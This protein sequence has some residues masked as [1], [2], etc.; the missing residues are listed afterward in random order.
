MNASCTIYML[1]VISLFN[2]S[3]ALAT[4]IFTD[5]EASEKLIKKVK[6]SSVCNANAF[7]VDGSLQH[8]ASPC[9]IKPA[10]CPAGMMPYIKKGK[11]AEC[12]D[13]KSRYHY[14]QTIDKLSF[15]KKRLTCSLNGGF[16]NYLQNSA[17]AFNTLNY[18]Q[19]CA[20][21][22]LLPNS[23][24]ARV[25]SLDRC[26][27]SLCEGDTTTNCNPAPGN[28]VLMVGVKTQ[29]QTCVARSFLSSPAQ[30]KPVTV[31]TTLVCG[32]IMKKSVLDALRIDL[33]N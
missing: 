14:N 6:V 32:K 10:I 2:V 18:N 13:S 15:K 9:I 22:G 7:L 24:L 20:Y 3:L 25:E 12:E 23:E 19:D 27:L 17:E 21:S 8:L 26:D 16:N 4:D 1:A 28:D 29:E 5:I 33:T 30:C 11:F 31:T